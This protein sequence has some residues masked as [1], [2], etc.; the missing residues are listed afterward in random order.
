MRA[1]IQRILNEIPDDWVFSAMLG[2]KNKGFEIKYFEEKDIEIL[3]C[4]MQTIVIAYIEP[5]I[6]Y[7][8]AN[9]IKIP[10]PL[11]IPSELNIP[12]FLNREIK[13]ITMAELKAIN[14]TPIFVKPY[15]KVKQFDS[16]V[17]EKHSTKKLV[18]NDVPDD[19]LVQT[20]SLIDFIT[21]YRCFIYKGEIKGIQYYKGNIGIFPDIFTISK[22]VTEYKSA[23]IAY[24]LDVGIFKSEDFG[25]ADKTLL[26][27]C[28]DMWSIGHY[29]LRDDIYSSMLRDRWFEIIKN[30]I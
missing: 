18:F 27:E 3:P 11:N 30:K 12:Q 21:E 7:F 29:G 22:M 5:T 6:K 4:N 10:H 17:L 2:L 26:V 24:S 1:Y 8:E 23:P 9:G 20:S 13:C 28:N 14:N 19:T 25:Y 16:G 15:G